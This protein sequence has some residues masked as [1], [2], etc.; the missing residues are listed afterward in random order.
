LHWIFLGIFGFSSNDQGNHYSSP[1]KYA[2]QT[3]LVFGNISGLHNT[4]ICDGFGF[5]ELQKYTEF[6]HN[7]TGF[8]TFSIQYKILDYNRRINQN[9]IQIQKTRLTIEPLFLWR[10]H[11]TLS[12]SEKE[13]LPVL[14]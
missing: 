1:I 3:E 10:L 4:I 13:N 14:S 2:K 7:N 6:D 8:N 5:T 11:S 12:L 9:F